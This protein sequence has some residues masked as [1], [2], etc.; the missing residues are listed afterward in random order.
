MNQLQLGMT[1]VAVTEILGKNYTIPE[2]RMEGDN[3]VE[4]LSYRNYPYTDE[5][6]QF[7]F[8]N[9]SLDEWYRDL[10]PSYEISED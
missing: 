3:E 8:V 10:I 4:V 9:G 7:V 6:Y 2:K 5:F 1:K